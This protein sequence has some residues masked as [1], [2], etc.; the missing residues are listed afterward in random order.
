MKTNLGPYQVVH[1]ITLPEKAVELLHRLHD[2]FGECESE[3]IESAVMS[4]LYEHRNSRSKE[5]RKEV[6]AFWK[7][8][9]NSDQTEESEETE[10]E[11][12]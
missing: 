4:H 9:C 8:W 6:M 12:Q 3:M 11:A 10:T 5:F 2:I 7:E 1:D